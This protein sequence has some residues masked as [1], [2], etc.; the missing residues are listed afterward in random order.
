MEQICCRMCEKPLAPN[1]CPNQCSETFIEKFQNTQLIMF[2]PS[3]KC[4]PCEKKFSC[5]AYK[6]SPIIK[7]ETEIE[8]AEREIVKLRSLIN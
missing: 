3:T 6:E 2:L 1:G 4:E 7:V 5:T 8:K